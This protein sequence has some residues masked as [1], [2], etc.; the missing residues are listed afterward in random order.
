MACGQHGTASWCTG[1][2]PTHGVAAAEQA[3][4]GSSWMPPPVRWGCG[5]G[6]GRVKGRGCPTPQP[7]SLSPQ[8]LEGDLELLAVFTHVV[9]ALS[10]AALL[11]TVAVLLSLR[12]LKSNMRGIHANVAAALG[13]AELL[14][15]LGIHRTQNQVQG[16]GLGTCVLISS[17]SPGRPGAR[18]QGQGSG[19]LWSGLGFGAG[20]GVRCCGSGVRGGKQMPG[21]GGSE[22][23]EAGE[24]LTPCP[25]PRLQLLCT[26]VAIL[27]HYFSLSTFAW[28][29]VQALHLY[30]MRVEPRN[31]DRGAMRFYHALGWGV[32]AVLLGEGPARWPVQAVT[33]DLCPAHGPPPAPTPSPGHDPGLGPPCL[34][35]QEEPALLSA[36]LPSRT[37]PFCPAPSPRQALLSAWILKAMGTPTSAGS[38]STN[39]SSGALQALS[40]LS[41]W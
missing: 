39:P 36:P 38:R 35:P 30:R 15:L 1:T 2:G 26:A 8:R 23:R 40:S 12:S 28:L 17:H 13:V 9:M 32:P 18:S 31:V 7:Q 10:V 29:Q 3:P 37:R 6:S 34:L 27:L 19:L 11:L 25:L 4:L 33:P 14:F 41:S 16:Q 20:Y 5:S 22:A 21:A 24:V